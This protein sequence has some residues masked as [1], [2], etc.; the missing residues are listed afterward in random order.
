MIYGD[1]TGHL[2]VTGYMSVMLEDSVARTYA[3]T[4]DPEDV[5][6][7]LAGGPTSPEQYAL[8]GLKAQYGGMGGRAGGRDRISTGGRAR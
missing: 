1:P 2:I 4:T 3:S 8:S 7:V 5:H 6:H